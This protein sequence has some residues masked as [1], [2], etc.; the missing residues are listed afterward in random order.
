MILAAYRDVANIG[1]LYFRR[2]VPRNKAA[3]SIVEGL[4]YTVMI[5]VRGP[6]LKGVDNK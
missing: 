5:E 6:L 2:Q 3:V 4:D 1:S